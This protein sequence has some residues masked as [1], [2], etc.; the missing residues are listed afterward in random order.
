MVMLVVVT[1]AAVSGPPEQ[2]ETNTVRTNNRVMPGFMVGVFHESRSVSQ[3]ES[4][5]SAGLV[6]ID[7]GH[8]LL[9]VARHFEAAMERRLEFV[10]S[11]N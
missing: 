1:G 5:K 10:H 4:L 3:R 9:P 11:D 2:A 8:H 6:L 7:E